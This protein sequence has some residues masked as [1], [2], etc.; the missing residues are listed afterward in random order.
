[1]IVGGIGTIEKRGANT[2]R[3][4]LAIGK[5]PQTGKYRQKSRTVHG[6]KADAFRER[7]AMRRELEQGIRI[8]ASK[9]TFSEYAEEFLR[10]RELKG[11]Y[12]SVTLAGDR[13]HIRRLSSYLGGMR[14][15]EIDVSTISYMQTRMIADGY[16]N[17][18]MHS[19]MGKLRQMLREAVRLDFIATNPCDKIDIPRAGKHEMT[20]LDA[21]GIGRLLES[22]ATH[23]RRVEENPDAPLSR[24]L[25]EKARIA[26]VRLALS[27]GMRR[28]EILGLE[29]RNVNTEG[30]SIH[31]GQQLTADRQIRE[32]K[33][34][35]GIR[36]ISIDSATATYLEAW[37]HEQ[38][39]LLRRLGIEAQPQTPIVSNSLGTFTDASNFS[40]WWAEFRDQYGFPNV[41][42]HDLRHT[43]ATLLIGNGVDIKTVQSRLGHSRAAT[44]LDT[45]ARALPENDRR[46]ADL[47]G[48]LIDK[49]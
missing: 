8:D 21:E 25:I 6:T 24:V 32:P 29:W 7:E 30:R 43:Q 17:T 2:W 10:R 38:S 18:M 15:R 34:R 48:S 20:T 26:G 35:S 22:L 42:F 27:T 37:H 47:F 46:A 19:T 3:I 33:T 12:K 11:A 4:R 23:E 41:R 13:M 36:S 44:T 1:M 14:L 45:Y 39:T 31:I 16:T 28:G 49:A 5:D 9:M 40:M